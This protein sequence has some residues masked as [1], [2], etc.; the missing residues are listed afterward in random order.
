MNPILWLIYTALNVYSWILIA[1][2][3]MSW[4]MAF[5]VLNSGNPTVRQ[6]AYGLRRLTEPVLAPIRNILPDLGGL[7]ISPIF[8]F[9]GIQFLQYSLVPWLAIK[10][11]LF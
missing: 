9:L 7:D 10:L 3:V 11:G 8:V 4:L 5:N 1:T 6:I 2:I